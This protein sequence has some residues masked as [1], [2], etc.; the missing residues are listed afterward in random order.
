MNNWIKCPRCGQFVDSS[1]SYC[2]FCGQQFARQTPPPYG[3]G[4][5]YAPG[6]NYQNPNY[7]NS[8][9]NYADQR[10]YSNDIFANAPE[11]RSRGLTAIFALL[12]G[13][14]GIHLF[15]TGKTGAGV[16]Y[17]CLTLCS[18]GYLAFITG[19]LSL[20]QAILLFTMNNQEFRER[21]LLSS[22]FLPF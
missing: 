3:Q 1:A 19:I 6:G 21:Y 20:I 4:P 14:L 8:Y 17:L 22:S 10:F 15:Y 18:C 2:K 11:G 16:L 12:L 9:Q 5:Q 13:S 7:G